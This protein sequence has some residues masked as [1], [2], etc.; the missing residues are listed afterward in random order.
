[1]FSFDRLNSYISLEF[2]YK[3]AAKM[4]NPSHKL[5]SSTVLV[6]LSLFSLMA[7]ADHSSNDSVDSRIFYSYESNGEDFISA[8]G[9]GTTFKDPSS[10]IG[11]Q[12]NTS[13]GR[14]EVLATDGYLEEYL[15]WE[16][17]AKFGFFSTV[18]FY[19]EGGFD[20]LEAIAE[21]YRDDDFDHD[22]DD[23]NDLDSFIGMGLGFRSGA[24]SIEGFVRLR[25]IDN[26]TWEAESETF[27]G[28]QI[29][30]NF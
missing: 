5:V 22:F 20:I 16:A 7:L 17:S 14:A 28:V 13:L 8:V 24:L 3:K 21:D 4:I 26:D 19:V 11:V 10:N 23:E 12:F 2:K 25:E 18:S 29:A 27:S 6:W 15:S 30:F 1:L 9:I